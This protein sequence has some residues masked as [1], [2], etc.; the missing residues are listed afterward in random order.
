MSR[1]FE[2]TQ[3]IKSYLPKADVELINRAYVFAAHAHARQRRSSGDL[4]IMHPLAVAKNL[5]D[6][7]LDV[8]SVVT[9][10]LH[11]TVEDTHV[12]ITDIEQRFGEEIARLVDGVTKVGKIHFRSSEHKKAENFR[13]MIMATAQDLRV[14]MVKLADRLH[15]METLHFM[16]ERKRQRI[17]I[18]TMEIY[19]PLAHRLGIHWVKQRMEDLAFAH[20]EPEAYQALSEKLADK[21][22]FLQQTQS[23]LEGILQEV[24]S[25]QGIEAQ[26]QGR[27][28]H[29]YSLH[30]KM[31]RKH[32]DFDEIFD[33][34]AFRVI[35]DD[36]PSC[37]Q[38]L[39]MIHSLYRPVPGRFKDYIA[40]PKPNG[41]QSLQTAV[42]GPDNFRIEVQIR[43]ESMHKYAEDGVASHWLY[44]SD[45]PKALKDQ[46]NFQ[47]LKQLTELLQTAE[48]PGEFLENVRLDLFV[49]EVYVFTRDGDLFALPRGSTTLDF[50][51]AI[52]TDVGNRCVGMRINGEHA[53][54]H[55]KLCNGDQI[56]VLTS[57]EQTPSRKWLNIVQ[58]PRA[59]QSIRHWFREQ[60][61]ETAIQLGEHLLQHAIGVDFIHQ[62]ILDFAA[63]DDVEALHEK[64]G[65]GDLEVTDLLAFVNKGLSKSSVRSS[66]AHVFMQASSCCYP[67]PGDTVVGSFEAGKGFLLHDAQCPMVFKSDA[68]RWIDVDWNASSDALY[69]TGIEVFSQNQ[70]G[71]LGLITSCVSEQAANIADLK[72]EQRPGALSSLYFLLEVQDRTHLARIFKALKAMPHVAKVRRHIPQQMPQSQASSRLSSMMRSV[73]SFGQ[74]LGQSI[75]DKTTRKKP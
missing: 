58:T 25:R 8:S 54:F 2:I 21:I 23:R 43:T 31:Q 64:L 24:L 57:T 15:N 49:Q 65:R 17:A 30:Q 41:Y 39:G 73:T 22:D 34:I 71:S 13:K 28:K 72:I 69:K 55:Y 18:E 20:I 46:Q 47:W 33:F 48:N 11:D 42:I 36:T 50:A 6:L 56:E 61:R 26:V 52:H 63:C 37:Y 44:K 66:L 12:T 51:Y 59:R 16:P 45:D 19:A 62:G 32:L 75:K 40:L 38:V 74:Q 29:M 70:R 9:G 35:V 67:I 68:Q 10:L 1:I 4:Y 14:L 5:V 53:D 27:M 60:E 7:K 3:Q